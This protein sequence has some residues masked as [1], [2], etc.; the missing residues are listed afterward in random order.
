MRILFIAFLLTF[1]LGLQGQKNTVPVPERPVLVLGIVVDQMRADYLQRFGHHF[2]K[3]G[4]RRMMQEGF[5]FRDCRYSYIPT[6]TAPGHASIFTGT[7]PRVHGIVGNDWLDENGKS[8]YC[9]RDDSVRGIGEDGRQGRMSPANM[10]AGSIADQIRLA[11]NF[12]GKAFGISLKDRGAIL[13]AGH[14]ANAAFW[15][16]FKNG[17]FIS[18]TWYR[19]LKGKLPA[20]LE[21]FNRNGPVRACM[22]SVWKPMLPPGSYGAADD[23]PWEKPLVEGKGPVFPYLLKEAGGPEKVAATPF[24]NQVLTMLAMELIRKEALGS[25]QFTDFLSLSYSSPDIIGH[26]YGPN[27]VEL[28][29]CYIRLDRELETLFNFLDQKAG[30]GKWL[31][32]LTA[33]HGVMENPNFLKEHQIPARNFSEAGVLD[34]LRRFS[35]Q[36]TGKDWFAGID[37]LQLYLHKAYFD[38]PEEVQHKLE[39][40]FITRLRKEAGVSNVFSLLGAKPWPEPPYLDKVSAGYY[41]KRS[42]H[43]QILLDPFY[44]DQHD[45]KGT[46]H[47]SPHAYDA[48]VPCLW[49]GWKIAAGSDAG[50]VYI[51]DIAPSLAGLLRIALPNGATGKMLSIPLK[52]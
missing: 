21:E 40:R 45:G 7:T 2:G 18:S 47:G 51:E 8:V 37:N 41:Q 20:W 29:D 3:G 14:G 34:S 5:S 50:S 38:L 24:G 11:G 13:P 43:L 25:D 49:L 15:F 27:S 48:Q 23:Q 36:E 4:F 22:D 26:S 17:N 1:P 19:D 31:C 6:Y 30:K 42:G 44:L 16:D 28:E 12:R 33:D 35:L 9:T 32:F 46:T 52:D 10:K 39:K